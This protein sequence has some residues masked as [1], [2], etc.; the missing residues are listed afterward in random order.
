M[1][2]TLLWLA[3]FVTAVVAGLRADTIGTDVRTYVEPMYNLAKQ[4]NS[5]VEFL[6]S[7]FLKEYINKKISSSEPGYSLFVYIIAKTVGSLAA[8]LFFTQ[9]FINAFILF[10]IWHFRDKM[11]VW[12][13]MWVFYTLF[14]NES[15]NIIRQWMAMSVLVYGFKYLSEQRWGRYLICILFATSFH[16]SGMVGLLFLVVYYLLS[17]VND[18]AKILVALP[19]RKI[20]LKVTI[21]A[22]VT[23]LFTFL[24]LNPQVISTLLNG[25]GRSDYVAGYMKNGISFSLIRLLNVLPMALLYIFRYKTIKEDA[26]YFFAVTVFGSIAVAQFS[27]VTTFGGRILDFFIMYNVYTMPLLTKNSKAL[28]LLVIAYC[29]FYWWY[30]IVFLRYNDTVP[31][32]FG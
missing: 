4:S 19:N 7:S 18:D 13:G 5:Y 11:N 26:R 28:K 20:S 6:N 8:N 25:I 9:L 22:L 15:L 30:Y 21:T 2:T 17:N 10:G 27:T 23:I 24:F 3:I 31:Y 12:L 16:S 14:Y 1:S 32:I 29:I